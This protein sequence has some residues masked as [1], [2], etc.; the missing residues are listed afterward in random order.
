MTMREE[1][2]NWISGG[3]IMELEE[4]ILD[5]EE[6]LLDI[7]EM[8]TPSCAHIGKRMADRARMVFDE[9]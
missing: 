3:R 8:R 4:R 6:A 5:L 1:I 2:A 9:K 7:I